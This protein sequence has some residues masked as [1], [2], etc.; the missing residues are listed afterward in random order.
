MALTLR[1]SGAWCAAAWRWPCGGSQ[2]GAI[3]G[4]LVLRR[5]DSGA[6]LGVLAVRRRD[7]RCD[8]GGATHSLPARIRGRRPAIGCCSGLDA[9]PAGMNPHLMY[10][11]P[12]LR[13]FNAGLPIDGPYTALWQERSRYLGFRIDRRRGSAFLEKYPH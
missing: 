5:R 13:I 2:F 8:T 1:C 10:G 3:L 12:A 7:I 4:D 6:I 9:R 11:L